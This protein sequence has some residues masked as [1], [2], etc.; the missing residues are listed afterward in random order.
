MRGLGGL[1]M[2]LLIAGINQADMVLHLIWEEGSSHTQIFVWV[3]FF[4]LMQR[5]R[6]AVLKHEAH[7]ES[8]LHCEG[9]IAYLWLATVMLP[10]N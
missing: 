1:V 2:A 10:V 5:H 3:T 7:R 8:T 6:S 4:R 9:A